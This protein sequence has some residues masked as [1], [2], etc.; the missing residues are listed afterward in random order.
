MVRKQYCM[1]RQDALRLSKTQI[2]ASDIRERSVS[3]HV[4][5]MQMHEVWHN[6]SSRE[7]TREK[8]AEPYLK[9]NMQGT[10][11][12]IWD[13]AG[14]EQEHEG[15]RQKMESDNLLFFSGIDLCTAAF[16]RL[17]VSWG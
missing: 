6:C 16:I 14:A 17:Y 2:R 10:Y 1:H 3:I 9:I 11:R 12:V 8:S 13:T 15:R 5:G 7:S 4:I